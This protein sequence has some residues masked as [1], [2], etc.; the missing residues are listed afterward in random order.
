MKIPGGFDSLRRCLR[1]R[2]FRLYIIGNIA[3]GI[4]VWVLRM[5]MGWLAWELTEST[6][7]LGGIALAETA[8]TLILALIAGTIVDR[9]DYFKMLRIA[10][11]LSMLFAATLAVLTLAGLMNIWLLFSLTLF[12]GCLMAFN[13]PSRM[14]LIYPLVGRDL[15]G[16]ALAIGSIIFNGARF[17]GPALGGLIVV[18]A[19]V[20]WAFAATAGLLCIYTL[21]LAMMRITIEPQKREE[22]SML[23]E[24]IEGVTYIMAHP[25][26]RLQLALLVVVGMLAR[27]VVDLLPGFAG[28]VFAKGADGL[29]ML[30]S[31]HGMGAMLGAVWLAARPSGIEGMTRLSILSM[32]FLGAV[33]MAFVATDIFAVAL[34]FSA[35][36]GTSFIILNVSNQTLIQSAVDPGLRGRVISVYG[37]ILQGVPALG[38]L[39]LGAIAEHIGLRLP[40]FVGGVICIAVWGLAWRNRAALKRSLETEPAQR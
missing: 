29:A 16:P 21:V 2:D 26:I 34:V 11:A 30:L 39:T 33:L 8:P 36:L 23:K 9:V 12:R 4:G 14:A 38:A 7:W 24:T 15:V 37:M 3:H 5:S 10:Q 6:A 20:G 32:F 19:G 25:G 28:Q 13:R 17:L 40:V 27:P 31:L 35:A 18:A 22:R 1:I